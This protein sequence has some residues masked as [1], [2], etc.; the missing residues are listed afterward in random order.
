MPEKVLTVFAFINIIT[1]VKSAHMLI[2]KQYFFTYK[3]AHM[4]NTK[5]LVMTSLFTALICVLTMFP[6][7]PMPS[8]L[9]YIHLGDSVIIVAA[10]FIGIYSLPAA[11]IGSALADVLSPYIIYAPAT[12]VI[13]ALMA[14]VAYIIIKKNDNITGFIIAAV[15]AEI[16]MIAL[17]F[18]YEIP[19]YG[20]AAAKANILF[21][22]IQAAGGVVFGV[23]LCVI[24]KKWELKQKFLN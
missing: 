24:V 7:I 3:D 15:L 12:F 4:N 19:L 20:L 11:A 13:K 10:F 18:S 22:L 9:G 1:C 8:G 16:I 5:K 2:Y 6:K 21:G 23:I 14:L 17:Y